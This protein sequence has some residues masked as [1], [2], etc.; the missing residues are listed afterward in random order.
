MSRRGFTLIEL[1]VVVAI[2]ALVIGL[3]L[4]ALGGAREAARTAQCASAI[5]QLQLANIAYTIDHNDRYVPAAVDFAPP[6]DVMPAENLHR[7]HGVRD[8][9]GEAFDPERGPL[10][11]YLDTAALSTATRRCPSFVTQLDSLDESSQAGTGVPIWLAGPTNFEWGSGGYGYNED[12]VGRIQYPYDP[13]TGTWPT[14]APDPI[15]GDRDNAGERA[16]RFASPAATVAFADAAILDDQPLEASF[17][18][19]PRKPAFPSDAPWSLYDP[20]T[21]FRH[22]DLANVAWLDGHVGAE[23]M[24]ASV[25]SSPVYTGSPRRAGLGWFGPALDNRLF[26]RR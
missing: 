25:D 10:T 2:V 5:R 17:V 1:L 4:P 22:R 12:Y 8:H 15:A 14:L 7:W 19:P 9:T 6:V 16:V 18:R 3:L 24:T 26:D 11:P 20:T 13:V 23:P 21:H